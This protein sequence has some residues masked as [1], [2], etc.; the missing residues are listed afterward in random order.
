V[1]SLL[2]TVMISKAAEPF[3]CECNGV[4]ILVSDSAVECF[5]TSGP[6]LRLAIVGALIFALAAFVAPVLF[7][8]QVRSGLEDQGS[9]ENFKTKYGWLYARYDEQCWYWEFVVMGRK[10]IFVA[11]GLVPSA[12]LVWVIYTAGTLIALVL[13][14]VMRPFARHESSNETSADFANIAERNNLV[15]QFITIAAGGAFVFGLDET[16]IAAKCLSICL[17]AI[18][19]ATLV[20]VLRL[21]HSLLALHCTCYAALVQRC[22][23]HRNSNNGSLNASLLG[24]AE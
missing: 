4:W 12:V 9:D 2:F 1:F 20:P 5:T 17:I 14:I 16:S 10:V 11:A 23:C 13:Q 18:N 6:W 21:M 15:V 24:G 7:F 22:S 3:H 8:R 19:F